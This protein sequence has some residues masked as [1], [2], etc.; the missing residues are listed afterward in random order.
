MSD[1]L[2]TQIKNGEATIIDVRSVAEYADGHAQ[3]SMN[4]PLQEIPNRLAEIMEMKRPIIVCCAS[5]N[6]SGQA[7]G[8]LLANGVEDV[9]NGGSWYD[10]QAIFES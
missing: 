10:V 2:I 8:F 6:R 3:A 7:E 4:I 1:K 5:G 9:Y